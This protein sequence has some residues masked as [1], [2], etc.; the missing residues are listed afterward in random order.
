ML[1]TNDPELGYTCQF[2]VQLEGESQWWDSGTASTACTRSVTKQEP[3][4]Y[5][6]R[7]VATDHNGETLVS[8]TVPVR[9][10]H[11]GPAITSVTIAASAGWAV[12]GNSI[13]LTAHVEG[14]A[15][16][17]AAYQFQSQLP[18]ESQ[19][20]DSGPLGSADTRT[21][22]K[23]APAEYT[24]RVVVTGTDGKQYTSDNTVAISWET[25]E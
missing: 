16:S 8:N 18:G 9:W 21:L 1:A 15:A 7:A 14:E 25:V 3:V 11:Q 19:W 13:T 6:F 24:M 4:D 23:T 20:W 10:E 22:T 5:L 17:G 2:Q 12:V